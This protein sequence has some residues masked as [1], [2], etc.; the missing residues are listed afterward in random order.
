[1][2]LCFRFVAGVG[3][4]V[5][6]LLLLYVVCVPLLVLCSTLLSTVHCR[7][8]VLYLL[9]I[10]SPQVDHLRAPNMAASGTTTLDFV[11]SGDYFHAIVT[12]PLT[13][14]MAASATC[15]L[16]RCLFAS[17]PMALLQIALAV[18]GVGKSI[19]MTAS[20]IARSG[21]LFSK[22]IPC[23]CCFIARCYCSRQVDCY[24]FQPCLEIR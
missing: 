5:A 19:V 14:R 16:G 8:L 2:S 13:K 6:L 15:E 7:G 3:V 21:V 12:V 9:I 1:L 23:H 10:V 22:R 11:L 4:T 20:D 17:N 24:S 18:T